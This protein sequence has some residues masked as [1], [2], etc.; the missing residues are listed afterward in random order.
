VVRRARRARGGGCGGL[1]GGRLWYAGA[2]LC[3]FATTCEPLRLAYNARH[4]PGGRGGN[5]LA[6]W[7]R[8]CFPSEPQPHLITQSSSLPRTPGEVR[9]ARRGKLRIGNTVAFRRIGNHATSRRAVP[10]PA[11]RGRWPKAGGGSFESATRL[12]SV[13]SA[14]TPHPPKTPRNSAGVFT[15]TSFSAITSGTSTRPNAPR[16]ISPVK[17]RRPSAIISS[18]NADTLGI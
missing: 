6:G 1:M 12:L 13:G 14:T 10:S 3:G 16:S 8:G 11:L 18:T 15:F 4:L 9:E 17:E 7:R 5:Y 2:T